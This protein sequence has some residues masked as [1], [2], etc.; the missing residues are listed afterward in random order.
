MPT[1]REMKETL[2]RNK[3]RWAVSERLSDTQQFPK[4]HAGGLTENLPKSEDTKAVDFK[5]IFAIQPNNPFILERR[6][7]RGIV[8]GTLVSK[9][10]LF[11]SSPQQYAGTGAPPPSGGGGGGGPPLATIDW[12]NRWG[13]PWIASIRDQGG[14]EACWVFS[15][16][17][18]VEAMVR[19]EHCAWPWL[20]E[21]DVHKGM[22]AKCCDCGFAWQALDWIKNNGAADPGCYAW[23]VTSAGC[24]GCG[25]SGGAPYDTIAYTPTKDRNG[26]SV[27]IP[28]YTPLGSVADQ[29]TWLDTPGPIITSFEI[30]ADF[31]TYGTGVYHKQT[32]IRQAP[33]TKVGGHYMLVV[34][35]DD[36]QGCWIVKNSWGTLW[37]Q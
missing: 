30:W 28:A 15:A 1:I 37:G 31:L 33:N 12:R 4:Y 13:W 8:A 22:G 23:P 14:S 9:E 35:Y 16:V 17:A 2:T 32:M 5:K 21:G 26:R 18:L 10:F 6:I 11:G 27:K 7:A 29:K 19:I 24:G 34:G 36:A 3:A 20:S 25:Q